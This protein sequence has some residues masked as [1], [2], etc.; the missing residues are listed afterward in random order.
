MVPT[1]IASPPPLPLSDPPQ[2]A[3]TGASRPATA[4]ST[5]VLRFMLEF[6]QLSGPCIRQ[7]GV[8]QP[9]TGKGAMFSR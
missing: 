8:V 3:S 2:A 4:G 5:K 6:L 7:A 9:D 1:T